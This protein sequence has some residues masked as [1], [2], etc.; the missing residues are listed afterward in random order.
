VMCEIDYV[1]LQRRSHASSLGI[2]PDD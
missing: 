2:S 1:A